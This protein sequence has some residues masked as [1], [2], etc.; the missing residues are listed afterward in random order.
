MVLCYPL[1]ADL[2][3]EQN[4]DEANKEAAADPSTPT[5]ADDNKADT[6]AQPATETSD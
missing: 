6:A 4:A 5:P 1:V 2:H 3:H